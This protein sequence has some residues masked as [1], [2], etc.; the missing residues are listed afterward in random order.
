MKLDD[1]TIG[2]ARELARLFGNGGAQQ[3]EVHPLAGKAVFIRT[4]THHYTGRAVAITAT[5]IV[6]DDA[7]W[8]A[9]DGR[10]HAAMQVGELSEVEPY[11]NGKLVYVG[12]GAVLDMCEWSHPLPRSAR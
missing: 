2:E 1:L 12:R 6:L 10:F 7:A 4:V 5:E 3:S 9:D 11:P 8:I